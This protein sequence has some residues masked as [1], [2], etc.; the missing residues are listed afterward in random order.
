[1]TRGTTPATVRPAQRADIPAMHRVRL[2]V[3]ENRLT[4]GAIGEA[5][6]VSA[7]E[8]TGRGWVALDGGEVVGFAVGNRLDGNIWALFVDPLHEGRGHGRRLHDAMVAWLFAQSLPRL[9][10]STDPGTRAQTFYQAAG[11]TPTGVR[12][13]GEA[14]YVLQRPA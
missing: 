7:I 10:L 9:W 4:S 11:W 13:D 3:R 6:Y 14:A 1:M 8:T 12:A 5:D 2:A